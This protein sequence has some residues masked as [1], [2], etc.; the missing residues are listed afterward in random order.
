M[1]HPIAQRIVTVDDHLRWEG[2]VTHPD[3]SENNF[4]NDLI[5]VVNQMVITAENK[6]TET[7]PKR[8]IAIQ[9]REFDEFL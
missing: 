9:R 4:I 8:Q 7:H 2:Y 1:E 6:P 3:S 5:S